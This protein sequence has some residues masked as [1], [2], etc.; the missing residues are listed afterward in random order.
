M[1]TWTRGIVCLSGDGM[2]KELQ[3]PVTIDKWTGNAE[4]QEKGTMNNSRHHR[5]FITY[6][7]RVRRT[8]NEAQVHVCSVSCERYTVLIFGVFAKSVLVFASVVVLKIMVPRPSTASAIRRRLCLS[9]CSLHEPEPC[10]L[11]T[12]TNLIT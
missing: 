5:A 6:S 1:V 12:L 10:Y 2:E 4:R 9:S 7:C 8:A 11:I 3:H